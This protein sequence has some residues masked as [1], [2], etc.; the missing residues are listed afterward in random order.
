MKTP[1]IASVHLSYINSPN[2]RWWWT[3]FTP[4]SR[5]EDVGVWVLT[6]K[7]ASLADQISQVKQNKTV[8]KT[9]NMDFARAPEQ[10]FTCFLHAG[11]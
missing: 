10:T 7:N 11:Y 6:P 9:G 1:I 5:Q 3:N 2:D 4:A 8:D